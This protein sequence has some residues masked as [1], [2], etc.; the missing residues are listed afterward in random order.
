LLKNPNG[1]TDLRHISAEHPLMSRQEF[2][3][4]DSSQ[5]EILNLDIATDGELIRHH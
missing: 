5:T 2:F 1:K 3:E 4:V